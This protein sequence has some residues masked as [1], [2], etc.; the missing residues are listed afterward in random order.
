MKTTLLLLLLLSSIGA[1]AAT[2]TWTH[3]SIGQ[4]A[5]F[6]VPNPKGGT[7]VITNLPVT[8]YVYRSLDLTNWTIIATVPKTNTA[9]VPTPTTKAFFAVTASN[10]YA[11]ETVFSPVAVAD[12]ITPAAATKITKQ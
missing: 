6:T 5:T 2:L 11:G 1:F 3:E 12:E 10:S 4:P 9:V 8:F 7:M